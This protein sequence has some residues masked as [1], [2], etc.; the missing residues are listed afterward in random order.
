MK[1]LSPELHCISMN[2]HSLSWDKQCFENFLKFSIFRLKGCM[3]NLQFSST[4]GPNLPPAVF[5]THGSIQ[6]MPMWL[7]M[8]KA[9][10]LYHV[11]TFL[12]TRFFVPLE[13]EVQNY[14]NKTGEKS[15]YPSKYVLTTYFK[16]LQR[17]I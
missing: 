14:Q 1:F 7:P 17:Y 6:Q 13:K 4:F 12:P 11:G 3:Q 5:L 9:K 16:E 15:P 2:L 10:S 8:W